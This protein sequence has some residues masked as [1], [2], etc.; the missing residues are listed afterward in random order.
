MKIVNNYF[1]IRLY[2]GNTYVIYV[3]KHNKKCNQ[4]YATIKYNRFEGNSYPYNINNFIY[5]SYHSLTKSKYTNPQ[6]IDK[7]IYE[8][9]YTK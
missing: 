1:K 6:I 8:L 2:D 3:D 9:L 5:V 4:Y 7:V